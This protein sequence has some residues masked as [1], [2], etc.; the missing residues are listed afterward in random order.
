MKR[1][2]TPFVPP[3]LGNV[4]QIGSAVSAP[5]TVED[6]WITV[7][8]PSTL[9]EPGLYMVSTNV[10]VSGLT[11]LPYY[12][13]SSISH[14]GPAQPSV[15]TMV[16]GSWINSPT[17]FLPSNI[18]WMQP[19]TSPNYPLGTNGYFWVDVLFAPMY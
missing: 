11:Q 13:F 5:M 3:V 1:L 19:N 10:I 8:F 16:A 14:L 15:L 6:D 7:A 9:L 2:P 4:V 12:S 17:N 18:F